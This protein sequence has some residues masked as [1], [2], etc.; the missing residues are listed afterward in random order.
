MK[1]KKQFGKP[2]FSKKEIITINIVV[3]LSN[4]KQSWM[5]K[6]IVNNSGKKKIKYLLSVGCYFKI[7][8]NLQM[9]INYNKTA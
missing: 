6:N 4:Q 5:K 7:D 2:L 9:E 3:L 8:Q 1:R